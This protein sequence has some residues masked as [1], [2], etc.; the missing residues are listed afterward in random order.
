MSA[1]DVSNS[2]FV[3]SLYRDH[4]S[5]LL[6]WLN[7]NLGCRQRAEDLSQDTFVRLLGRPELPGLREPRVPGE[8]GARSD[9]RPLPP[10]RP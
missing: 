6:A 5:W 3:G 4:R 8:G 1:G 2:E 9:D 7:R 10:R